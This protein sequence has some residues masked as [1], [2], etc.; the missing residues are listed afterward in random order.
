[1][2]TAKPKSVNFTD[3]TNSVPPEM[4]AK[5]I[6][7]GREVNE[8]GTLRCLGGSQ[9]DDWNH[10]LLNQAILSQWYGNVDAEEQATRR[11]AAV[12]MMKAFDPKDELEAM[13]GAQLLAAHSAA[14][15]CYRRAMI[16]Q[17]TTEGRN[18]NLAQAN[19][20]SRTY[21]TLVEALNRHRGKGGQQKVTVEH[22]HVY[23]GGQAAIGAFAQGGGGATNSREQP[24]ERDASPPQ[25]AL[26]RENPLGNVLPIPSHAERTLPHPRRK[27][28]RR[29]QG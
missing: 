17:Q 24:H 15:E 19:K 3:S 12:A 8:N 21:A 2:T 11:A 16:E 29:A 27:E 7:G 22:V 10:V 20:L 9:S 14:M 4:T 18:A 13:M 26:L 1:M 28:P 6:V 5:L 25:P 23:E